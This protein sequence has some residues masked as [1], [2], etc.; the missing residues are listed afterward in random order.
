MEQTGQISFVNLTT[1]NLPL[2]EKEARSLI[3]TVIGYEK[4]E[5]GVV[6]VVFCEDPYLADLNLR[7]LGHDTYTDVIAFDYSEEFGG[8]SGDIFVSLDRVKENA[9]TFDVDYQH[10]LFR[11]MVHGI[12]HLLGHEDHTDEQRA[13]MSGKEN[14]YLSLR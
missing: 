10:E 5:T 1:N 8:V 7:F 4:G 6:N 9:N 12:L 13:A 3:Q 11:V 2:D 14:Y